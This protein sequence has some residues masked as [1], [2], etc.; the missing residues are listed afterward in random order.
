MN[1]KG[2][3]HGLSAA[4]LAGPL[5]ALVDSRLGMTAQLSGT[6]TILFVEDESF[7]REVT[8][9]VLRS[10]GYIVLT[11]KNGAEA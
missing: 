11:A 10:V 7:V 4:D 8:T 1:D 2:T 9:E 6:E 3:P 5:D